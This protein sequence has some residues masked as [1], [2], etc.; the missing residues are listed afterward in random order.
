MSLFVSRLK[1]AP[2]DFSLIVSLWCIFKV[3]EFFTPLASVGFV[4]TCDESV[5][6][7]KTIPLKDTVDEAVKGLDYVKRV[8]VASRT[9]KAVNMERGRDLNL[10]EVC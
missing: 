8:Y 4:I 3:V 9:G 1:G 10:Q 6:G 7:N 5:R 2:L